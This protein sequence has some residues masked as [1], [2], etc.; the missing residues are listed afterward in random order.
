MGK[1]KDRNNFDSSNVI[2]YIWNNRKILLLVL[3]AS[4]IISAIYSLTI[5]PKYKSAVVMFPASSASVSGSLLTESAFSSNEL[6]KFGGEQEGE[7]LMQVL[8]SGEIRSR[9]MKKY[10]L[11]QH[12]HINS[13]SGTYH[14]QLNVM[15]DGNIK[16]RRTEY[17]SVVVEVLD[18]DPDTAALIANDIS[19]FVDTVMNGIIHVRAVK[20]LTLVENEY[21][22]V[23]STIAK[24]QDSLKTIQEK[25]VFNYEAQTQSL[26]SVYAAAIKEG[27][28]SAI[29][30]LESQLSLLAKY[31]G[32]YVSVR[33][34][35]IKYNDRISVLSSKYQQSKMDAQQDLP[36]KYIVEKAYR[37]DK[38]AYP[39]RWLIVLVSAI[40]ALFL[41][42][43]LLLIRDTIQNKHQV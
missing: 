43:I 7:Q 18:T 40:S 12:Y 29:R 5:T 21:N 4:V 14:Y 30:K 41:T 37:S 33:D 28:T 27:N 8:Q 16:F 31:G 42:L 20:A 24:L 36:Y 39:V 38:K 32:A 17:M 2:L 34:R 19:C 35:L 26:S 23:Q 10:N 11:A 1:N 3:G 9:I 13:N 25:G 22:D 6:L 15:Y